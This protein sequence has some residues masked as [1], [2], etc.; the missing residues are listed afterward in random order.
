MVADRAWPR[1]GDG[2]RPRR[3]REQGARKAGR[4]GRPTLAF[5]RSQAASRSA[6]AAA[7]AS[8]VGT[9]PSSRSCSI[10]PSFVL[11]RPRS[12]RSGGGGRRPPRGRVEFGLEPFESLGRGDGKRFDR[13]EGARPETERLQGDLGLSPFALERRAARQRPSRSPCFWA[14]LTAFRKG[15]VSR[16]AERG[17]PGGDGLGASRRAAW[18]AFAAS[19]RSLQEGLALV[20]QV[21]D[22]RTIG[23]LEAEGFEPI[24]RS[25]GSRPRSRRIA[26]ASASNRAHSASSRASARSGP[27]AGRRDGGEA[28]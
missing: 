5:K 20:G 19:S 24:R 13:V 3:R 4:G 10:S 12:R 25:T 28:P 7:S 16:G 22:R 17:E 18:R 14:F 26:W 11:A 6:R 8:S 2:R 15:P 23:G 21:V 27:S 9:P 1:G